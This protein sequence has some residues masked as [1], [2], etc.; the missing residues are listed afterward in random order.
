MASG[1]RDYSFGFVNEAGNAGRFVNRWGRIITESVTAGETE[2]VYSY[3]LPAGYRRGLIYLRIN[4]GTAVGNALQVRVDGAYVFFESFDH[5][6]LIQLSEENTIYFSEAQEIEVKIYNAD[7][8]DTLFTGY[9]LGI[10]ETL[11]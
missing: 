3:T 1:R 8:V 5:D 2:E 6:C 9:L 7:T 11:T 10:T 4:G